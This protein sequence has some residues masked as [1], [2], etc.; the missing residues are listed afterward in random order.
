VTIVELAQTISGLVAAGG[1]GGGNS[2]STT[3]SAAVPTVMITYLPKVED[4]PQRR[5]FCFGTQK[6]CKKKLKLKWFFEKYPKSAGKILENNSKNFTKRFE[7][8]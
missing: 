6:I 1:G 5:Y 2:S 8:R 3:S 7:F 4:D